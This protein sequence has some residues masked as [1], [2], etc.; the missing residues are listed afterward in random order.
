MR[1]ENEGA[2]CHDLAERF[3][4]LR[5]MYDEHIQDFDE[6]IP[7]IFMADVTRYVLAHEPESIA[8]VQMLENVF[9]KKSDVTQNLIQASF[10][11]NIESVAELESILEGV[12][13]NCLR[14]E[15]RRQ[16]LNN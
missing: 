6:L 12:V 16:H 1:Y 11:E 10:V 3:S 5:T 14:E 8:I 4:G 2:L 7:H 9:A 15:W 13:G